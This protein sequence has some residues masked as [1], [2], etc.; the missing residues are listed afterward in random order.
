MIISF[1]I[2][3]PRDIRMRRD[4]VAWSECARHSYFRSVEIRRA[5]Q[6]K[7]LFFSAS[8]TY[9]GHDVRFHSLIERDCKMFELLA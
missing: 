8:T 1:V 6:S 7:Y 5:N 3:Q 2:R 9:K 4:V